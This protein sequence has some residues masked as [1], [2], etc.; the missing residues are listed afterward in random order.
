[1]KRLSA[2]EVSYSLQRVRFGMA[3][4]KDADL[5]RVVIGQLAV[6]AGRIK[7]AHYFIGDE[8]IAAARAVLAAER[9][10]SVTMGSVSVGHG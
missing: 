10:E 7:F 8:G 2:G 3:A 9:A 4:E 6:D 5:L 1:M